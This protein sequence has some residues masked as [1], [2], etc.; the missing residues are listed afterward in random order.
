VVNRADM[1]SLQVGLSGGPVAAG[2][3]LG[4]TR[5][6]ARLAIAGQAVWGEGEKEVAIAVGRAR[7]RQ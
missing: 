1:P 5:E 7:T 6:R 4:T 3:D 2:D